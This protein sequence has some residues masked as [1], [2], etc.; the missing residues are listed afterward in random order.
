MSWKRFAAIG[1]SFTEGLED[2]FADGRHRGWADRV[3]NYM[4]E[5]DPEFEYAN[6]AIRGRKLADIVDNQLPAAL[7]MKPDLISLCGGVNDVL[8]PKWSLGETGDLLESGV[9]A[10]RA[11]GADVLM[12]VFGDPSRRSKTLG[13]TRKR[14]AAYR[15]MTIGIAHDQQ[16]YVVDLWFEKVFDDP[17]LWAED[18]LHL[19]DAGHDRM[20]QAAIETLG[21]GFED[22]AWRKPLPP[23]DSEPTRAQNFRG[24]AD[25]TRTH[26][27]PWVAR[28]L[29]GR[30]SGD[31]I[32]PKRPTF[33]PV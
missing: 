16:C 9:I 32:Q 4:A 29:T 10:A 13:A 11:S 5:Q 1:D 18:R 26:L 31:D 8:R 25:W 28:R 15:E 27:T 14:L 19:N 23:L 21:L 6:L 20:A 30:S 33:G 3:A 24:N 22:G 17:R 2:D 12:F 7:A